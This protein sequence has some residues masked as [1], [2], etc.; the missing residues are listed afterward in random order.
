MKRPALVVTTIAA[1][2]MVGAISSF[3]AYRA[4]QRHSLGLQKGTL[5]GTL[6][7]LEDIRRGDIQGATKRIESLCFMSAV[8]LMA[9]EH[10][11]SDFSVRTFTPTLVSYRQSYR[12]NQADWTPTE[13]RLENL[14]TQ[15][16]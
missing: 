2:F 12:T 8:V 6:S 15:A 5:V 1:L 14:L 16:R 13:Q 10:Y 11:Q 3:V 7:A 9:D 4:G